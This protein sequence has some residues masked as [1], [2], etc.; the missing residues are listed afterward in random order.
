MSPIGPT[1]LLLG[2]VPPELCGDRVGSRAALVVYGCVPGGVLHVSVCSIGFYKVPPH[3]REGGQDSFNSLGTKRG[4]QAWHKAMAMNFKCKTRGSDSGASSSWG[5]DELGCTF[6]RT[7]AVD[8]SGNRL[9]GSVGTGKQG[10]RDE[11]SG[12]VLL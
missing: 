5:T 8:T 6:A 3:F 10:T 4:Y 9:W 7:M 2:I 11:H 1:S 12:K